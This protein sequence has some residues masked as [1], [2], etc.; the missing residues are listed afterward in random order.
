MAFVM[1]RMEVPSMDENQLNQK[2]LGGEGDNTKPHEGVVSLRNMLDAILGG[3]IDAQVDVAVRDSTQA[4][5]ASGDG[6]SAS[7]NLK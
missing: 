1:V 6:E 7:Y 4:I 5:S 3:S 2:A